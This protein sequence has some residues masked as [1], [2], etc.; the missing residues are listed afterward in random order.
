M[1][2]SSYERLG[3]KRV[4][5]LSDYYHTL[6][7]AINQIRAHTDSHSDVDSITV[8]LS[9]FALYRDFRQIKVYAQIGNLNVLHQAASFFSCYDIGDIVIHVY[10]KCT[11]HKVAENSLTKNLTKQTNKRNVVCCYKGEL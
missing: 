8:W 6:F 2:Y 3:T 9:S 1:L 7:K 4:L 10:T 11:T 5:Q